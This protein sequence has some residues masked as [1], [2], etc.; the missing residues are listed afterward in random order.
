MTKK[1]KPAAQPADP[2][3]QDPALLALWNQYFQ[4]GGTGAQGAVVPGVGA[5]KAESQYYSV[6]MG[7]APGTTK[8]ANKQVDSEGDRLQAP[9]AKELGYDEAMSR[10]YADPVQKRFVELLIREGVLE[11]GNFGW[12]DV[13]GW[14]QKAVDGAAKSKAF[15]GKNITPY[16]W[17]EMYAGVNGIGGNGAGTGPSTTHQ[18]DTSVQH[19]DDLDARAAADEAWTGLYGKAA[20]G[21]Q[22]AALKAALNAYAK[23]HPSVASAT[24]TDDGKGNTTSKTS[25]SGGISGAGAQQIAEDQVK[26]SSGYG[27]YQA[28]TTYFNALQQALGAT[29]DV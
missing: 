1:E 6:Y 11:A 12:D 24:R 22:A 4:D 23:A 16:D 14:W 5:T 7:E 20:T 10:I 27:E 18:T 26:G 21:K 8:F 3:L 15:G 13:E 19:F 25:T 28:A 29:A 9:H 17:V 2:G